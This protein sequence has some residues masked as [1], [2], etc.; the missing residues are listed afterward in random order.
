M[1]D[2]QNLIKVL[3]EIGIDFTWSC[4]QGKEEILIEAPESYTY[5]VIIFDEPTGKYEKTL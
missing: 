5:V 3:R 1:S 2:L 4:N